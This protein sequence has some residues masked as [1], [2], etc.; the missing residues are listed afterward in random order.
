ME[1][2]LSNSA[3]DTFELEKSCQNEKA[4][5]M[6]HTN[7]RTIASARFATAGFGSPS[8][9]QDMKTRILAMNKIRPKPPKR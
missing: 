6:S 3:Y 2:D 8:G 1:A 5:C 4:A 7:A 9:F